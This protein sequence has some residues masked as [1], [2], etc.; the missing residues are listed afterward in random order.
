MPHRA[1]MSSI[2]ACTHLRIAS[3]RSGNPLSPKKRRNISAAGPS[4]GISIRGW[5]WPFAC[6]SVTATFTTAPLTRATTSAK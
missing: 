5:P 3:P 4:S 1:E 6:C 2:A